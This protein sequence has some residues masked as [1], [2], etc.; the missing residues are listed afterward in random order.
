MNVVNPAKVSFKIQKD[1]RKIDENRFS[2]NL[3]DSDDDDVICTSHTTLTSE[4]G[5][6]KKDND[7]K[8]VKRGFAEVSN[9]PSVKRKIKYEDFAKRFYGRSGP[10][11]NKLEK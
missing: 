10:E 11:Q 5:S 6:A 3:F 9:T 8:V 4:V 2:I 7:V 1:K